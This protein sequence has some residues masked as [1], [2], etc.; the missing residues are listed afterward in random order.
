MRKLALVAIAAG[1]GL[2]AWLTVGGLGPRGAVALA[3]GES[4]STAPR[5]D[6]DG[7]LIR[8]EHFETWVFVGSSTGLTYEPGIASGG[9]G[10]FHDVYIRPES[11]REYARTGKFPEKTMLV[12]AIYPPNENVSPAKGGYFEGDLEGMAVAV[13]DHSHFAEGW[14]YFNF[15]KTPD[16]RARAMANPKQT[17]YSCHVQHAADDNVFVQFY[18]ILRPIMQAH[19]TNR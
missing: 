4:Q 15:G 16:L 13:K 6:S 9:A 1:I 19:R 3:Q 18:P 2:G 12:L 8:P 14:A 11:Y 17:C 7:A 10:E 5:Y